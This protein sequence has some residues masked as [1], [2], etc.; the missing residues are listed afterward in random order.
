MLRLQRTYA[1]HRFQSGSFIV[2]KGDPILGL[3]IWNSRIP[4]LP[5]SG[6]DL[7]WAT[8]TLHKFKYSLHL[9][10]GEVKKNPIYQDVCAV[11]GA[12]AL[13]SPQ[14]GASGIHPMQRLG[15]YVQPFKN[16]LGSWGEFFENAFSYGIMWTYNPS[17]VRDKRIGDLQRTELWMPAQD[18][19][20]RYSLAE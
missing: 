3:H 13:F 18:F 6:P 19:L 2:E 8:Q 15:F 11:Y 7:G 17:S 4:A 5:R 20:Q 16:M 14:K 1:R 10:A 12:T 9:A